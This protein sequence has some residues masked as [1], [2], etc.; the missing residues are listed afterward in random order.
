[1]CLLQRDFYSPPP[2]PSCVFFENI[3]EANSNFFVWN[4]SLAKNTNSAGGLGVEPKLIASKATVL[5]LD[6]P[7]I[8]QTTT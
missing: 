5:P 8:L 3:R 6:D 4:A 7:P 1:M 2:V